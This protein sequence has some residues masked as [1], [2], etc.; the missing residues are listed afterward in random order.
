MIKLLIIN[1]LYFL[2]WET[3]QF[4]QTAKGNNI[5]IYTHIR[6][7]ILTNFLVFNYIIYT[8][9]YTIPLFY[10]ILFKKNVQIVQN[11]TKQYNQGTIF[12]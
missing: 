7:P 10:N 2:T 6:I 9:Q 4:V 11:P 8:Y 3:V 5:S 1:Y 12:L